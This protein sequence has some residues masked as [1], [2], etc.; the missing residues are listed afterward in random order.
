M[1]DLLALS[2]QTD[3]TRIATFMFA[4]EGSNRN[5]PN[6][7]I[8]EGHHD[9]S[10]HGNDKK[11]NAKI[12]KI[13]TFQITQLAYLLEKL[14]ASR[15]GD[16]SLLDNCMIVFGSGIG[17]GNKHNHDDLPILLAGKGGGTIQTGR[18]IKYP[19]HTPLNNLFLSMLDR[20]GA[21]VDSLG[22]SKGRLEGL[23]G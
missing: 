9:L 8:P 13:N 18:H 10:H 23:E 3:T 6:L 2:F 5:Y 16:G 22:D 4:N 20:M 1:A 12:A 15:E 19:R 21:P 17:D 11:K 7:E 14:K